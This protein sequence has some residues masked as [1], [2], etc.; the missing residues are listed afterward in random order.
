MSKNSDQLEVADP[1]IELRSGPGRGY[2][3]FHVEERG[4]SIVLLKR[5]TSWF[6]VRTARGIEGW[7]DGTQLER[8]LSPSGEPM[9]I[10]ATS[11]DAYFDRRWEAGITAGEFG[12]ANSISAYGAYPFSPGLHAEAAV[13][14]I[15][16]KFTDSWLYS[17]DLVAQPFPRWR[18]AP[19]FFLGTGIIQ[20]HT[21][22]SLVQAH[23]RS[24]QVSHAGIGVQAYI[25]RRLIARVDY[26]H[27]VIFGT[28]DN[29]NV[30]DWRAGF[31]VF[32]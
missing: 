23:D 18:V 29:Q 11:V 2:P 28:Q 9:R 5:K 17:L 3:I 20:T 26:R 31:A 8:T 25:T 12:G 27:H 15:L 6:K 14:Q 19:F 13:S 1:Y 32:F 16:G 22:T 7:V 21:R 24:D 4:A 10:E 30:D